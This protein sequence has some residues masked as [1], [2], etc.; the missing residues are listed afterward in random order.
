MDFDR[1]DFAMVNNVNSKQEY[2]EWV[3]KIRIMVHCL[4]CAL[5]V[6]QYTS[7]VLVSVDSATFKTY[8]FQTNVCSKSALNFN[9]LIH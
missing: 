5:G 4:R 9:H 2:A 3:S 1:D 6:N 7:A 8:G